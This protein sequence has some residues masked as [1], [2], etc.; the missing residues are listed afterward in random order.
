[1][2]HRFSSRMWYPVIDV[3]AAKHRVIWFDNRGAG[4]SSSD[5]AT[6]ISQFSDD[7]FCVMDAAGVAKAHLY[8]V[9]MGGVI[10]IDMA[11]R[12]PERVTSLIVG[13]SGV[14]SAD[15]PR[16]PKW[17]LPLYFLPMSVFKLLRGGAKT[18]YGYGSAA[19]PDLVAKDMAMLDEDPFSRRGV[20]NQALALS[21]YVTTKD[22]VARL[23]MP[24]LVMHGD[25]DKLVPFAY[26]EELA[27]TLPHS[28][29]FPMR[30]AGHNYL[31]ARGKEANDA[32]LAFLDH[33]DAS[34]IPA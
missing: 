21:D 13:C 30:G 32:T 25:E 7:G 8:G 14:F 20:A 4:E 2:G 12:A 10:V 3:L 11:L 26:G 18:N 29:F 17:M 6:K 22:A 5:G 15:K 16:A 27:N 1:M 19:P 33:V 28:S 34:L 24:S 31:I 23:T 9:S